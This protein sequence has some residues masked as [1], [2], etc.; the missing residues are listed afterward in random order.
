[1]KKEFE[2]AYIP[3]GVGT[4]HL[5]SAQKLMDGSAA[6]LRSLADNVKVP[7]GSGLTFDYTVEKTGR[8]WRVQITGIGA[9]K[10]GSVFTLKTD[11]AEISASA[12]SYAQ[13]CRWRSSPLTVKM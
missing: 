1:M 9:H 11:G 5:E 4:F 6:L 2:V 3:V 13:N 7:A 10:L 8:S 12:L